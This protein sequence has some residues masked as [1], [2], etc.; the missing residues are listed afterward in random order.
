MFVY[1]TSPHSST[2]FSPHELLYGFPCEIPNNLKTSPT[3]YYNYENY[4]NELKARLQLCHK[5]AKEIAS[6]NKEKSKKYY[7]K[8]TTEKHFQVGDQ[9]LLRNRTR[10]NKLSPL[11]LGPYIIT[12]INST[13]NS[14][15]KVGTKEKI[16]HN[17]EI[18]LF[19]E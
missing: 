2:N 19:Q 12:K 3:T 5:I 11:W 1:N 6:K 4:A 13:E 14:T 8:K 16:I 10:K 17:N 9:V 7:D 18:K 15:I